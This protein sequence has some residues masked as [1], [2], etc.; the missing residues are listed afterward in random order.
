MSKL[1]QSAQEIIDKLNK[2]GFECFAVGGSVRDILMRKETKGWDFTTNA[3]PNEIMKIF[4]D[5]FYDNNFGTVGI[6]MTS[7]QTG[8]PELVSGSNSETG[9]LNIYLRRQEFGMT[10]NTEDV[11][12]ITTY[13]SEKGYTDS[14]HPD[15]IMWGKTLEEDLSRR[16]LT[17]NAIAYDGKKLIDPFNGQRD[18]KNR[19]IRSV[20]DPIQRFTE[21]ALRLMRTVRIATQLGFAIEEKTFAAIKKLAP[22]INKVSADRIRHELKR[23]LESDY[24][25]DGIM[26]LKNAGIL[27]ELLPELSKTFGVSQI[28]PKRHHIYDVGTHLLKSLE[29]TPSKNWLVRFATLIHDIGKPQVFRKDQQTNLIT[30]YNHEMVGTTIAKNIAKRL[31][32]SKKDAEKFA[33]LVRHHQFTVDENQTDTTLRRFVK[34]VGKENL[35][36]ILDLRIGDRVGGGVPITS[37]RLRLFI[38]R[39]EEVQKQPFTVADL[40]VDGYDV[41]KIFNITPGPKI[42]KIL[43]DLFND[44]VLGKI[45]ND[46][47][48]LLKKLQELKKTI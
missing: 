22:T 9:S 43:N 1:P 5:S 2:A 36:D 21:D 14:R 38:K 20:G 48:I 24:P 28:S 15:E 39:L 3:T 8:H 41:M 10:E 31:N 26:I 30:F 16:D 4:P 33:L 11:Y 17:I 47:E 13:R 35:Q 40:K 18:L 45:K 27:D 34:K 29:A 46:R 7:H 6:K 44:V 19:L 12:E 42:G 32:F 23:I 25:S 37:W